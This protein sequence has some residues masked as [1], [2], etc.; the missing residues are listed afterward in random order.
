M[1][2]AISSRRWSPYGQVGGV[3]V[4]ALGQADAVEPVAR[5]LD[6]RFLG[7]AIAGEAEHAEHGVAGRPHQRVVLRD[8]E[9]LEH[10]HLAEQAD[11]LE[12]PGDPGARDPEA[13]HLLEQ[14][15]PDR[16]HGR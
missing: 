15:L 13:V 16:R 3:P 11:V 10:A 9:V 12:G 14:Q 1:A 7:M 4:G 8:H 5:P 2:R 6:R